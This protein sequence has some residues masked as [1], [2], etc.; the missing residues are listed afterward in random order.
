MES[1]RIPTSR[2]YDI[3]C[4]HTI[5]GTEPIVCIVIHGFGGRK[6]S[7][8]GRLLLEGLPPQGIGVVAFDFPAHGESP[9]DGVYLQLPNC[10]ADI[11]DTEAFARQLAPHAEIVYFGSSFGAY[12]GLL[13][14]AAR[15]A[16]RRRAFLRSAAVTM[17]SLFHNRTAEEEAHLRTQG[18]FLRGSA[19]GFSRDIRLTCTFLEDLD[20]HD[21]F[22]CWRPDAAQVQMIHGGA[23]ELIPVEAAEAF[24]RRFSIPITVVPDGNH[25]LD[26]PG[27]PELIL[28]KALDFFLPS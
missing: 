26:G 27:I 25:R 7:P 17:P 1:V 9:V 13:Y 28:Q 10:L 2:G 20:R 21:L 14:L 24:A 23:D 18:W 3:P 11:A 22:S 4:L 19:Q 16:G 12:T 8:S 5:Q 15:P 6:D